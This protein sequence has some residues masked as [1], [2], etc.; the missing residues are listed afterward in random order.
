M[1]ATLTCI[2]ER[3]GPRGTRTPPPE[4]HPTD[5][6]HLGIATQ[7]GQVYATVPVRSD[8]LAGADLTQVITGDETDALDNAHGLTAMPTTPTVPIPDRL[9]RRPEH[10]IMR[11]HNPAADRPLAPG[12]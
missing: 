2:E 3:C 10:P 1:A 11:G 5:R 9:V 7:N 8:V 12:A 6:G 4:S